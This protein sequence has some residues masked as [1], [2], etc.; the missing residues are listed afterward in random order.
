M[1]F[2]VNSCADFDDVA[3]LAPPPKKA[4]TA[5]IERGL[6]R[7]LT[8]RCVANAC[9]A[10]RAVEVSAGIDASVT[11]KVIRDAAGTRRRATRATLDRERA[12]V[13]RARGGTKIPILNYNLEN[14]PRLGRSLDAVDEF[15]H[16][17]SVVVRRRAKRR[18][19]RVFLLG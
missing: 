11:V 6:R 3:D 12:N 15:P 8:P 18:E 19:L 13:G 17:V 14:A 9:V 5:C 10:A 7:E 4:R 2:T 1:S 16:L